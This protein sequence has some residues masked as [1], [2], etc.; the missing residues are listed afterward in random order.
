MI[1]L[2]SGRN[3][4]PRLRL[5][6]PDGA[7]AEVYLHGAHVTSWRPAGGEEALF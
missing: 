2:E 1:T 6:T 5:T 3:G 7:E 4:L